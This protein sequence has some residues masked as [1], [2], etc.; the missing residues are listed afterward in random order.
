MLQAACAVFES[1][2]LAL[3]AR[4][5]TSQSLLPDCIGEAKDAAEME[6]QDEA[7]HVVLRATQLGL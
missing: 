1:V 6:G 7:E 4:I 2:G 5:L 3:A